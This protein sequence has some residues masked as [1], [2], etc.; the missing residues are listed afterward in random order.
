MSEE[1]EKDRY[2]GPSVPSIPLQVSCDAVDTDRKLYSPWEVS[3]EQEGGF[4]VLSPVE[5]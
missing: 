5:N 1:S 4:P 2:K 3:M